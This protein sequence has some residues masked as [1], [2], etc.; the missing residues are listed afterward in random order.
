MIIRIT[1]TVLFSVLV[2]ITLINVGS[3]QAMS[4]ENL[5]KSIILL[6]NQCPVCFMRNN[7]MVCVYSKK[8]GQ[9][10]EY[11]FKSA[12]SIGTGFIVKHHDKNYVVTAK[13]VA[14]CLSPNGAVSNGEIVVN[15]SGGRSLRISLK[16]MEGV[17]GYRG[18]KW[19]FHPLADV[20]VHP[21]V[22]PN[23]VLKVDHPAFPT[24]MLPRTDPE[25]PLLSTVYA[26]GF[27]AGLGVLDRL[28]PV[29]KKAQVASGITH[30]RIS[31]D[32]SPDLKFILLDQALAQGYSGAPIFYMEDVMASNITAGGKPVLKVDENPRIIG[33]CSIILRDESGGKIAGII[34]ISYLWDILQSPDFMQYEKNPDLKQK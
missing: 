29:A 3:S 34:P 17:K 20:A 1:K 32:I 14:K 12:K 2:F 31:Q 26:L 18:A 27:P 11:E 16:D 10:E 25:T 23:P 28:E 7:E 5:S 24:D 21:I 15:V 4:V 22:Y 13:H 6:Y 30:I 19:F 33:I 8:T 9:K